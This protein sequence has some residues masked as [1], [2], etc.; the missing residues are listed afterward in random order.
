[1]NIFHKFD[2]KLEDEN[3]HIEEDS[4]NI[5]SCEVYM[6]IIIY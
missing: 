6:Y 1:M 2:I 5:N 3:E 4:Y